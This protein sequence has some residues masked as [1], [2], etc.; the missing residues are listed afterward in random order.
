LTETT[1]ILLYL[2]DLDPERMLAPP[3]GTMG[4][5]YHQELLVYIATEVHMQMRPLRN[6]DIPAGFAT[7]LRGQ[8]GERFLYLQDIL[9]DRGY[10][11]GETFTVADAYLFALLQWCPQLGLDIQLYPN[12]DDYEYRVS[13][14]PA[15][16]DAM[17]AEGMKERHVF[18]E[19]A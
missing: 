8:L 16:H 13:Q 1:A 14:R 4:R 2:A 18:R 10:L 15:V 9:F 3:F 19:S 11:M 5:Y 17:V 6:R 7:N 12:L